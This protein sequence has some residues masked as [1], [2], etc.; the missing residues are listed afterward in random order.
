MCVCV[1]VSIYMYICI[2]IYAVGDRVGDKEP[3]VHN[4]LIS[5]F[6]KVCIR[7]LELGIYLSI[8]LSIYIYIYICV[9]V[10]V[11]VCLHNSRPGLDV[12][13]EFYHISTIPH[14][15]ILLYT[16]LNLFSG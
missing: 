5:L 12:A 6:A 7:D 2:Y 8:Y 11:C 13:L 4:Y 15:R 10:C 16:T 3:A 1:C 9:C 14:H